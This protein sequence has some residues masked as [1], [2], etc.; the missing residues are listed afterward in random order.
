MP[1]RIKR[2]LIYIYLILIKIFIWECRGK[3]LLTVTVNEL[4]LTVKLIV[5]KYHQT[6]VVLRL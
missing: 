4:M 1:V 6:F 3:A 5:N 2:V